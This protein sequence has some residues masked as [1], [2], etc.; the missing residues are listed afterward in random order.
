MYDPDVSLEVLESLESVI[1]LLALEILLLLLS[2][3]TGWESSFPRC[4][5]ILPRP[6]PFLL[7][8]PL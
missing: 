8:S 2:Q 3:L 1:T 4:S 5:P 6:L 7:L